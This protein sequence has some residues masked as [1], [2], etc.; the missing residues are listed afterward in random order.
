MEFFTACLSVIATTKAGNNGTRLILPPFFCHDIC[1]FI[2]HGENFDLGARAW[3]AYV[4]TQGRDSW[5]TAFECSLNCSV[6]A[7]CPRKS[8]MYPSSSDIP[9]N[10]GTSESER[11]LLSPLL[12][13][14]FHWICA[15]ATRCEWEASRLSKC[16]TIAMKT[17]APQRHNEF[18]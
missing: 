8:I 5:M 15:P 16:Q 3:W 6:C 13:N 12:C 17:R 1:V 14:R 11:R 7:S 10:I 2:R 4:L 18:T 9:S